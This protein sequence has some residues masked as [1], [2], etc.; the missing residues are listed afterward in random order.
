VVKKTIFTAEAQR[1][2]RK[3]FYRTAVRGGGSKKLV[4]R[5]ALE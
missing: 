4:L 2:Q 5:V 3:T 1:T